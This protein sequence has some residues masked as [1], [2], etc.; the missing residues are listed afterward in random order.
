MEQL[1]ERFERKVV[2]IVCA[3][4]A[5]NAADDT[6]YFGTCDDVHAQFHGEAAELAPEHK[7]IPNSTVYVIK[8][9]F[10]NEAGYLEVS[11]EL[12]RFAYGIVTG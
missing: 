3:Y 12:G 4:E 6:S 11:F 7:M 2:A 1:Q 5:M 9:Q 8:D 10:G